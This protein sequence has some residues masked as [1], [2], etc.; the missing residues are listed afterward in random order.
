MIYLLKTTNTCVCDFLSPSNKRHS[1]FTLYIVLFFTSSTSWGIFFFPQICARRTISF[2]LR[3]II[4]F[5]G[6][7]VIT[8]TV[9]EES[10]GRFLALVFHKRSRNVQGFKAWLSQCICRVN[11]ERR[12]HWLRGLQFAIFVRNCWVPVLSLYGFASAMGR[13]CFSPRY[14]TVCHPTFWPF[15]TW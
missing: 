12:N 4:L 3:R 2:L 6:I 5:H 10:G 15:P 1:V 7:A 14:N 9:E 8:Q 11:S 13:V